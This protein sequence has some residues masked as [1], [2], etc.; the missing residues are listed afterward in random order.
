MSN[1]LDVSLGLFLHL[2]LLSLM[3]VGGGVISVTPDILRYVVDSQHWITADEFMRCFTLAQIAP[4][5]NFLF[6][7]L[8]GMEA[9]G[10][11]GAT[12]ATVALIVPPALLALTLLHFGSRVE[13]GEGGAAFR[14]AI[15]PLSIGMVAASAWSLG[16]MAVHTAA[17]G[18][19][20]AAALAVLLRSRLNPLWLVALGAAAGITGLV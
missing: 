7:T 11:L 2:A 16:S 5:P 1:D 20:F 6:A 17:Q 14:A 15:L 12:A 19:L 18:L 13:W 3:A 4:G 8:V 10:F 9:A